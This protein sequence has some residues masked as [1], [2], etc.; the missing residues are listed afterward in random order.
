MLKIRPAWLRWRRVWP[1]LPWLRVIWLVDLTC[2]RHERE[3]CTRSFKITELEKGRWSWISNCGEAFHTDSWLAEAIPGHSDPDAILQALLPGPCTVVLFGPDKARMGW[4]VE[5]QSKTSGSRAESSARIV[6]LNKPLDE[7][8][9]LSL[10]GG[11]SIHIA[12][13]YTSP[14]D[15]WVAS[16][17]HEAQGWY[18]TA[19]VSIWLV[20]RPST[21]DFKFSLFV[22]EATQPEEHYSSSYGK[23]LVTVQLLD[24]LSQ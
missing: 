19:L 23:Q 13:F 6:D 12:G 9:N 10:G 15:R 16:V 5:H 14:F 3:F 18:D 11:A 4:L 22:F 8:G 20:G 21:G 24:T 2:E 1:V 17:V 7:S